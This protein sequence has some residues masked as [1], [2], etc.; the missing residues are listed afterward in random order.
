MPLH[1]TFARS[2][3]QPWAERVGHVIMSRRGVRQGDPL[4][5]LLF[6]LAVHPLFASACSPASGAAGGVA[7]IDDLTVR[8][9]PSAAV[10]VLEQLETGAAPLGLTVSAPKSHFLWRSDVLPEAV[11]A[12]FVAK[13]LRIT[14][15][16]AIALG[17]PIGT[18]ESAMRAAVSEVIEGHEPLFQS[19]LDSR[20][21]AQ[22]GFALLRVSAVPRLTYLLRCVRP[23]ITSDAALRFESM[24]LGTA[25]KKLRIPY[26]DGR[27]SV[28]L[29]RP[30][31]QG[32]FGLLVDP[33]TRFLAW[34]SAQAQAAPFLDASSAAST[35]RRKTESAFTLA[36]IK[37]LC[38]PKAAEFLPSSAP[39]TI[40]FYKIT[41]SYKLQEKLSRFKNDLA[42]EECLEDVDLSS[43]GRARIRATTAAGAGRWKLVMPGPGHR[44]SDEEMSLA[45][46]MALGLPPVQHLEES[47]SMCAADLSLDPWHAL[48]CAILRGRQVTARHDAVVRAIHNWVLSIGGYSRME[49]RGLDLTSEKRPDLDC[50]LGLKRFLIDVTVRHPTAPS[51]V[52]VASRRSLA[53]AE[54][55]EKDKT[56]KFASASRVLKAHFVPFAV[57]TF[58]GIGKAARSFVSE[59]VKS[60]R[61]LQFQWV[62]PEALYGLLNTVAVAIQRGNARTVAA[63]L[64]GAQ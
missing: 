19:I 16:M 32:G 53:V 24:V 55:A 21:S 35:S 51:H 60:S 1:A 62:P 6:S 33:N 28:Q 54:Q 26:P 42:M 20:L 29:E 10:A 47:C 36:F 56:R 13:G 7:I 58:G 50:T 31:R 23:S 12:Q 49:P 3:S 43:E 37:P 44:L 15:G 40:A 48:S 5:S 22:E 59:M 25:Q 34:W 17:A 46:R 39:T 41:P 9:R 2:A 63:S 30:V 38:G 57:E 64:H 4:G 14:T 45:A 8:V 52:G 18:D 61:A 11:R 27:Q